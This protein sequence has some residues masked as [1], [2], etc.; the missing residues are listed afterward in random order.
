[1]REV[2]KAACGLRF[3]G[4]RSPLLPL[5]AYGTDLCRQA[6]KF[7]T[8]SRQPHQIQQQALT[9]EQLHPRPF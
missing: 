2:V 8:E 6:R 9:L 5:L 1:M 3:L 4:S 7:K